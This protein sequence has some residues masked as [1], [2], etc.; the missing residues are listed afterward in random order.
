MKQLHVNFGVMVIA[1]VILAG[2]DSL[3]VV[4][5][6][7]HSCRLD[8]NT[9]KCWGANSSGQLGYGHTQAIGDDEVPAAV[10]LVPVGTDVDFVDLGLMHSCAV[11]SGGD[12]R[13]W[14]HNAQG[15]LG[16][17]G[18][19][20]IGDDEPASAGVVPVVGTVVA[21][22]LGSFHTCALLDDGGVRCW[23]EG[24][25]G[26]LGG[27]NPNDVLDASLANLVSLG[28]PAV[29][30]VAGAFHTCARLFDGN[31]R[32]WG[33]NSS[34]ALGLGHTDDIGD[35]EH[36]TDVFPVRIG[37]RVLAL[38]AG[39]QHTCALLEGNEVR[40][41]GAGFR[42]QLGYGNT[43]NVG[44]DEH[45]SQV[46]SIDVGAPVVQISA[47]GNQTCALMDDARIR[48]WGWGLWGALGYGNQ[49]NVG[50]VAPPSSVGPVDVGGPAESVSMGDNH[51]CALI[52]GRTPQVRCWG[53]NFVG[54]LGLGHLQTI[55]DD[56]V[57]SSV[58]F[59]DV[60]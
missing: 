22:A 17:V 50:D 29:E 24:A 2:C 60:D 35:D 54:E 32:C 43:D 21:V 42:G 1:G 53:A 41:W 10:G 19:L 44:D 7:I 14:G 57:P 52:Q 9:L 59:V 5:G 15:Q 23:G 49:D 33:L 27:A 28:G 11:L 26:Q 45:P 3:P 56:E 51:A 34:G 58:P 13:C 12:L 38:T 25:N 8:A 31:V 39:T 48:C 4:A 47:G 20:F 37:A 16:I 40:C 36:P 30:I 18:A 55:G 6:G 46:P